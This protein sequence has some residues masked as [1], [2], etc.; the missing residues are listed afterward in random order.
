MGDYPEILNGKYAIDKMTDTDKERT[1]DYVPHNNHAERPFAIIKALAKM[2]PSMA[3]QNLSHLAHA[4]ANGTFRMPKRGGKTKRI[5]DREGRKAGSAITADPRL[6]RVVSEL[7]SA[8]QNG[9]GAVTGIM[10]ECEQQDSK[11]AV[12]VRK[13]KREDKLKKAAA[14]LL[15]RIG[16]ENA[17]KETTLKRALRSRFGSETVKKL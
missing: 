17:A 7:C 8:R 2:Y 6:Q 1:E 15:K 10:R 14:R 12:L 4:K 5:F 13:R 9:V 16:T 3:L 11:A